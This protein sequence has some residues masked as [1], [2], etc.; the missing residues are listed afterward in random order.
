MSQTGFSHQ[1]QGASK[2]PLDPLNADEIV[3]VSSLLKTEYPNESLHFKFITI[4]EPPKAKLRP[5][6]KAERNG[7]TRSKLPRIAS[8]LFYHKGTANLFLAEVNV[9]SNVIEKVEKLDSGLHGQNDMDEVIELRDAC[10]KDP[11]VLDEI[12]KF[13]LP[14]HMD[15][16]C[17]TWPYGRDSEDNLPRYIQVGSSH[18]E[19]GT[20]LTANSATYL[21]RHPTLAQII[22]ITLY[23]SHLSWT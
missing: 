6:L 14:P 13:K 18:A 7:S 17:D 22:M 9:G 19:H 3:Q 20:I 5:F 11:K 10:L 8:A 12:K 21:Q 4:L 2:H 16:V 1:A 23:H 15:V